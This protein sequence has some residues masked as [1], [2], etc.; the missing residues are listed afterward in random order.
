MKLH[1]V[2]F[3]T[4]VTVNS[5]CNHI[6]N[7]FFFRLH[8]VLV[9]I[10]IQKKILSHSISERVANMLSPHS[11]FS[12]FLPVFLHPLHFSLNFHE[13]SHNIH[14]LANVLFTFKKD[15]QIP[16]DIVFPTRVTLSFKII[17]THNFLKLKIQTLCLFFFFAIIIS[18]CHPSSQRQESKK[19]ST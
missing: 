2:I 4:H 13:N 17:L 8:H 11:K 1:Q 12:H 7:F 18:S 14:N 9:S 19:S 16:Y 15:E 10:F 6:S 5:I 3:S